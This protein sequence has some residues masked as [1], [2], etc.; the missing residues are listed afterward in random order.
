MLDIQEYA[1]TA[2]PIT[3]VAHSGLFPA[4]A[5]ATHAKIQCSNC[6]MR[7]ICM[8]FGLT[9]ADFSRLDA[10]VRSSRTV[11]RG[12]TLYR[13]G[14]PFSNIYAVRTGSFKTVARHRD[15]R[16]QVIGFHIA[17]E[18][19]GLDGVCSEEHV[20]DAVALEDSA[21]CVIPFHLL[22]LLCREISLLQQHVH[23]MMSGE[24]VREAG[25]MML[26]GNMCAEERVA[27]FLLNMSQRL[28]ARGYS[29]S[30]FILRMTREE[31]GSYLGLKLETISRMLS[32]F[33]KQ[34]MIRVEGKQIRLL[35]IE[36][37]GVV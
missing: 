29:P 20:C 3:L 19:L 14:T 30:E 4:H 1:H 34:A 23:K 31:I 22:E 37:L 6:G 7:G 17:G 16:E 27:T 24:I 35:D 21:I 5:P 32:R 2:E 15:G 11:R 26:L 33:Q 9:S 25:L 10:I 36:R 8:P 12:E 18:P 13:A 28:A